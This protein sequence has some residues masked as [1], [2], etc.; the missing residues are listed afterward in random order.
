MPRSSTLPIERTLVLP[1]AL[2]LWLRANTNQEHPESSPLPD[3]YANL[4][5][6]QQSELLR[7][8]RLLADL[9]GARMSYLGLSF[10]DFRIESIDVIGLDRNL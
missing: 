10:H 9:A 2:S 5:L 8:P 4:R 3:D 6:I 1:F 7:S